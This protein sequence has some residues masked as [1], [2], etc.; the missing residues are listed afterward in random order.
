MLYLVPLIVF[1]GLV[2]GWILKKYIPE[3][4]KDAERYASWI[5]PLLLLSLVAILF[6]SLAWNLQNILFVFGGIVCAIFLKE[7]YFFFACSLLSFEMLPAMCMFLYGLV[8]GEKKKI[9]VNTLFFVLPFTLL[10]LSFEQSGVISF[11]LG[12][13]V[14]FFLQAIPIPLK[15]Y[16]Q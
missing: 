13:I 6:Y 4:K 10:F 12:G 7:I 5:K 11:G 15:V 14:V 2:G 3:E 9:V 1:L 8:V 16:K